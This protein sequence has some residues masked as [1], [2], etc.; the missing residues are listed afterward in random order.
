MNGNLARSGFEHIA[1]DFNDIAEIPGFKF[2]KSFLADIIHSHIGLNSAVSVLNVNEVCLAHI[3]PSHNS[4]CDCDILFFKLVEMGLDFIA[5][6]GL[7]C[8]CDFKWVLACILKSLKLVYSDLLLLV[9]GKNNLCHCHLSGIGI[10][11]D[12]FDNFK[13]LRLVVGLALK[14]NRACLEEKSIFYLVAALLNKIFWICFFLIVLKCVLNL[15]STVLLNSFDTSFAG[16][17]LIENGRLAHCF[18]I[19]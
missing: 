9:F 19:Y 16:I 17:L 14:S 3:A 10:V 15:H 5:V 13:C 11:A 7:G 4:A 2:F 8:K 12:F 6:V 1:L 18:F